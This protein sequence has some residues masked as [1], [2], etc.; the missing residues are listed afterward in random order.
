MANF[1]FAQYHALTLTPSVAESKREA[2]VNLFDANSITR[3]IEL[4]TT[5]F[6]NRERAA[7]LMLRFRQALIQASIYIWSRD[8]WNAAGAGAAVFADH[9]LD[10]PAGDYIGQPQLWMVAGELEWGGNWSIWELDVSC[11]LNTIL[12]MDTLGSEPI[13]AGQKPND[14]YDDL[15]EVLASRRPTRRGL[16]M[17]LIF[18]P[19]LSE[20]MKTDPHSMSRSQLIGLRP[21]VLP[22]L[23]EGDRIGPHAQIWARHEFLKLPF[24][25]AERAVLPRS[26]RRRVAKAGR[27]ESNIRVVTLRR[28]QY[29]VHAQNSTSVAWSCQW[30]VRGHWR[31]QWHA[32]IG[33]H[34]ATWV[35]PYVK[36]PPDKPLRA[37]RQTVYAVVR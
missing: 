37:P 33:R 31:N 16:G 8:M 1:E 18:V 3:N 25:I 35:A 17:A 10:A 12:L 7:I 2:L 28:S 13:A 36:G 34:K 11:H 32:S 29:P 14:E 24:V 26:E 27:P 30:M 23:F 5:T 21:R 15:M 20:I 6:C 19:L 22:A 9:L 4:M